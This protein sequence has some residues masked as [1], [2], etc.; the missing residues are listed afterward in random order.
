MDEIGNL[1][2]ALRHSPDNVPLRKY[3]AN[4]LLKNDRA[5][6]AEIEFKAAL[7]L[8]P[9]DS[10]C[11]LGLAGAFH[12]QSKDALALVVLEEL[13]PK[14]D[15]AKA[16]LLFAKVL[17]ATK[18]PDEAKMAYQQA[19]KQDPSL[20]DAFLESK[21]NQEMGASN[22]P[23]KIKLTTGPA[24]E[25]HSDSNIEIERPKIDF[26]S[27]GGME[28]LKEEIRMKIIHP[29]NNPEIYKAYGKKIGGGIL[30]YGPPGC[31]KTHLARAT[32]GEVKANFIAVG[33]SDILDMYI[34]QSERN[35]HSIFQK[36]RDLKPCVL[37]FDEVDALG[38]N[39]TDMRQSAGRHLINQF[40]AELDGV[41]YS[42]EGVLI[43]AATN[44][45]WHL[46]PAFRRPG[47]FDR[48]LFVPPPDQEAR[49][50]I[51]NIHLQQ[52]PVETVKME[53]LAKKTDNYSGADIQ[54]LI[55]IAIESKLEESLKAGRPL[56]ISQK[57]LEH[58]I[59]QHKPT[60]L[61][62][63]SSAKNYALFANESGLYDDILDYL[64]IKR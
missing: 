47:R 30:M 28:K 2:E 50:E 46:D 51:L 43:L 38:A 54:A 32:A 45:P 35:L 48:I 4:L 11:K 34:G 25:D 17:L 29:L 23:E 19:I 24:L 56:P 6:E 63:F 53:K 14:S 7:K 21:I 42:N 52:K 36:A 27:V 64:K 8:K 12:A 20:V 10:D 57:D 31:G 49:K 1:Q 26:A 13:M 18:Q 58:A 60:T 39:R 16:Q 62:W 41:E 15:D 40:L 5:Q 3:L 59:R 37:F 61:E 55:D 33:I 22:E 44:A 9:E